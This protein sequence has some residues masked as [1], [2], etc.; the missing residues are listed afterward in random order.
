PEL[1]GLF[2]PS[3]TDFSFEPV[4]IGVAA[5]MGMA[6]MGRGAPT[7]LGSE[8]LNTDASCLTAPVPQDALV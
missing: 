8:T 5:A 2:S 4:D 1:V 7:D 6:S 3:T